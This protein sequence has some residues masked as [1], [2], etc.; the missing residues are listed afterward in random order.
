MAESVSILEGG[1]ARKFYPVKKLRTS[2]GTGYDNWVPEADVETASLSVTERGVYYPAND[3]VYGYDEVD[4]DLEV[5]DFTEGMDEEE[6]P[7]TGETK[8]KKETIHTETDPETGEDILVVT[9][10]PASIQIIKAPDKTTYVNGQKID[11]TGIFVKA[12][13]ADGTEYETG[14][15]KG[16]VYENALPL[17]EL[18]NSPTLASTSQSEDV[19]KATS[20]LQTSWAQPIDLYRKAWKDV[21]LSRNYRDVWEADS[22]CRLLVRIS[23]PTRIWYAIASKRQGEVGTRYKIEADGSITDVTRITTDYSYTHDGKT[24]YYDY[25]DS[26]YYNF[27]ASAWYPAVW[28]DK[29]NIDG[30]TAWTAIYGTIVEAGEDITVSWTP[31]GGTEALTDTF[32]IS[33]TSAA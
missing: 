4:I 10:I 8:E 7:D 15:N 31:P 27:Q 30:A 1:I 14:L 2:N 16:S 20:D 6:D 23:G 9:E 17:S 5:A 19:A 22:D 33:V 13:M 12:Y 29:G 26:A 24:V 28:P 11:L 18:S 32:R 3:G 25:L 21:S